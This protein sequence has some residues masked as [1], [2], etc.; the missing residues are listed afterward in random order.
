MDAHRSPQILLHPTFPISMSDYLPLDVNYS[1]T[2]PDANDALVL[3]LRE[4]QETENSLER[5]TFE[6]SSLCAE[7]W[8]TALDFYSVGRRH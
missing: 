2:E 3:K 7:K 6:L 1:I 5:L 4:Y 8:A